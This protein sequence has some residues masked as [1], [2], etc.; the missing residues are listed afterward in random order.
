V[1]TALR[2]R[3]RRVASRQNALVKQLRRSFRDGQPGEDGFTA[4]EGTR[5]L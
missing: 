2:N 4:I 1:T 5:I 3:L